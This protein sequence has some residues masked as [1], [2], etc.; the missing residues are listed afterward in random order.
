MPSLYEVFQMLPDP[1]QAQG[2]KF[3]LTG[4]LTLVVIALI[5]QQN[6]LRQIEAWVDGLDPSVGKPLGFR[7]GRMPGYSTI[8]RVLHKVDVDALTTAVTTWVQTAITTL[9]VTG[10]VPLP[11][12]PVA[13]DGKT[14]RG[15]ADDAAQPVGDKARGAITRHTGQILAN[16]ACLCF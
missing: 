12:E 1:H 7:F 9:P 16:S 14:L 13:I 10:G 4:V 8:R 15:S 3:S 11:P 5:A 2:K 6:S